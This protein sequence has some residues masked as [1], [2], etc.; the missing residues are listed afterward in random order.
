MSVRALI[1]TVLLAAT[2]PALAQETA[3]EATTS[4]PGYRE[5]DYVVRN[6]KFTGGEILPEVK[7]HYRAIGT[8]KRNAEGL[9]VNAV[10]LLQGNTGT[11]ANWFRSSLA[12]ELFK[13]GQPLDPAK[14]YIIMPDALGRGGSSK[15][16]DSLKAGFP[17]YRYHDMVDLTHLL[18]TGG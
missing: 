8:A 7:L 2:V 1:A 9:V 12:D 10:L 4:W 6:Y 14:Y 18:V 3:K 5:G 11:G 16:S 17:H 15:P 13:P